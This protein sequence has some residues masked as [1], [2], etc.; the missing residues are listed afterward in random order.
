MWRWRRR[1]RGGPGRP[2][3]HRVIG[4][5]PVQMVFGPLRP[6][7]NEPIIMSM[8]EFEAYRLIY[9]LGLTQEEAAERMGVSRGTV[10]RCLD[11]ARKKL[12]QMLVEGRPLI[13]T[14]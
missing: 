13:I 9:Y 8:D 1:W 2:M 5:K 11:A 6:V 14:S 7:H 3:K 4:V 12:A 10:W